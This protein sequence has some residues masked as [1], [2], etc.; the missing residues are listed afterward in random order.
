MPSF[1]CI[2]FIHGGFPGEKK[3]KLRIKN[4][5][6]EDNTIII[7]KNNIIF[8]SNSVSIKANLLQ[9]ELVKI[10]GRCYVDIYTALEKCN[11]IVLFVDRAPSLKGPLITRC[12]H[13]PFSAAP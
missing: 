6:K 1:I 3:I 4:N 12:I 10:T 8:P 11:N 5:H 9:E 13:C 2:R 7:L